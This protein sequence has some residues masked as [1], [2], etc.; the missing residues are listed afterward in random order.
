MGGREGRPRIALTGHL[1]KPEMPETIL[2]FFF[3]H[4]RREIDP[5]MT[6]VFDRVA[7]VD[8]SHGGCFLG[9]LFLWNGPGPDQ[10][11]LF[12]MFKP[13][14]WPPAEASQALS[15]GIDVPFVPACWNPRHESAAS[16][17]AD[18]L[19]A[20]LHHVDEVVRVRRRLGLAGVAWA[21]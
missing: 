14:N 8:P 2:V 19:C 17:G 20:A 6:V 11:D 13:V 9:E 7:H 16:V 18:H 12:S 1:P 10:Q 21:R 3:G 5:S 4:D 15:D